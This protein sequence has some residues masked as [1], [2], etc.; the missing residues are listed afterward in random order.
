MANKGNKP[1][2]S[3]S[4]IGD[5]L[6]NNPECS[7]HYND[8][9]FT[10]LNKGR[11]ICLLTVLDTLFIKTYQPKICKQ[12]LATILTCIDYHSFVFVFLKL[13]LPLCLYL[14]YSIYYFF[15]AKVYFSII[16][17]E[18]LISLILKLFSY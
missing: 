11:N 17:Y 1:T 2:N 4:A 5:H 6:L 18:L 9:K 10:I 14:I 15:F 12:K 13:I 8:N 7:K 3:R 16:Y